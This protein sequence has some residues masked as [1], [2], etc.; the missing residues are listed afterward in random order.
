MSFNIFSWTITM[1]IALKY[2]TANYIS[3]TDNHKAEGKAHILKA[4]R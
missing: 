1:K 4:V 2:K 3:R